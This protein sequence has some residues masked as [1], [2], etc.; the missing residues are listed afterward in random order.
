MDGEEF[1]V[2]S[3][4]T[5]RL[6]GGG[7]T[8]THGEQEEDM[9]GGHGEQEEDMDGEKFLGE[10]GDIGASFSDDMFEETRVRPCLQFL[11]EQGDIG[12]SFSDD[13]FEE[14]RVQP[15]LTRRM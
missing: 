15:C 1:L 14:T 11:G 12:A 7:D 5:R 4:R 13:M 2:S 9:D 3:Q 6:Q 10:Q 8:T